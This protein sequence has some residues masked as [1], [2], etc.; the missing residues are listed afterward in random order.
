[1]ENV[2]K[3]K[4]GTDSLFPSEKRGQAPFF[5]LFEKKVPVPAFRGLRTQMLVQ[6]VN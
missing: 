3:Q 6:E 4:L 5:R 1:M 2:Y